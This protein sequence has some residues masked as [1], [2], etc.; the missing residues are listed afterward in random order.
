M[1]QRYLNA[2]STQVNQDGAAGTSPEGWE[3]GQWVEAATGTIV[4]NVSCSRVPEILPLQ[5]KTA[6]ACRG[7]LSLAPS[8]FACNNQVHGSKG[9]LHEPAWLDRKGVFVKLFRYLCIMLREFYSTREIP[10]LYS[11]S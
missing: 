5:H 10:A 11:P 2:K 8:E 3:R 9:F 6:P 1:M 4:L 7:S